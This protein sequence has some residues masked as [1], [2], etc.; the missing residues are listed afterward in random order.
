MRQLALAAWLFSAIL[1]LPSSQEAPARPRNSSVRRASLFRQE[2]RA[3]SVEQQ[4][5]ALYDAH[6]AAGQSAA[7][8]ARLRAFWDSQD[9][10]NAENPA[11]LLEKSTILDWIDESDEAAR[12]FG[13]VP[14]HALVAP[15]HLF[16]RIQECI[17]RSPER[18][19]PL[20]LRLAA[21]DSNRFS[22]CLHDSYAQRCAPRPRDGFD[23]AAQRR[24]LTGLAAPGSAA[25]AS[26]PGLLAWSDA[27]TGED[28]PEVLRSLLARPLGGDAARAER[29]RLLL[30]ERALRH[31]E[32]RVEVREALEALVQALELEARQRNPPVDAPRLAR[33]HY[34]VAH[35]CWLFASQ[36]C[37]D[38]RERRIAWLRRA[39]QWDPDAPDQEVAAAWFYERVC[40]GGAPDYRSLCAT[41]LGRLGRI[42]E[43][44][45][46]WL[47]LTL[48]SPDR[49]PEARDEIRRLDPSVDFDDIWSRFLEQKLP[50][51]ADFELATP[52][53]D[54]IQLSAYRGRWVLLDFWG[55]WCAPCRQ[56]LPTLVAL[57]HDVQARASER[58]AVLTV[59]CR[60]TP[61][62]VTK[63][64]AE[65]GYDLPVVLGN[66]AVVGAFA[67]AGYPTKIL[68]TPTGRW[69]KLAYGRVDWD[70]LARGIMLRP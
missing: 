43:A 3:P 67:V 26:V 6:L 18:A 28:T 48:I 63:F 39:A 16:N 55:T 60:D 37:A 40:L 23:P 4:M 22:S 8:K 36:F 65:Q 46:L 66:D 29:Y 20:L 5:R 2:P 59:A 31:D 53:G 15:H 32:L 9:R 41:E 47:E 57:H 34:Y 25:R 7:T 19:L 64:L 45:G 51:A 21:V 14:D 13:L 30:L 56:E 1:T 11:Y 35:A 17:D 58:A 33:V 61:E 44:V 52:R 27:L 24:L 70:A 12:V 38:D 50:L 69:M 54:T 49:L 68:I 10:A 62:T 42:P